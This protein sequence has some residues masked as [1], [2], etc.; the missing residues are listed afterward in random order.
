MTN[1]MPMLNTNGDLLGFRG[2]DKDITEKKR[3]EEALKESKVFLDNMSDIAYRTDNHGNLSWV[4]PSVKRLTGF[5]P[6]EIIGEPF[7]PLFIEDDHASIIDLYKRTL[8]GESLDNTLTFTSGV[9]CHINSMPMRNEAGDI[10]GAFGIGRDI[11]ETQRAEEELRKSRDLL[12]NLACLVPGAIYQYRLYPDGSSAFPWS[13]PGMNDIYEVTPEDAQKDA[14]LV[15][16][17]LHPEDLAFVND[18]IQES[19][20]TLNTLYCEYR[21]SLPRQGLQWRWSQAQPERTDDGGTL[22]HGITSDITDRKEIENRLQQ[23]QKMESI[24]NL[25]GGI[26]HDFNNILFPI[27]GL[28]EMLLEDLPADSIEYENAREILNAG[29]R[30]SDLVKQI[31][32]F[33][34]QTEQKMMPVRVQR[35]L[36]EVLKLSRSTIPS[37][38]EIDQD[39]QSDCG[40]VKANPTQVHQIAMNL[41]T[42]AYHAVEQSGGKIAVRLREIALESGDLHDSLLETGRYALISISDTGHG[43]DPAA[44][45][46]IFEPYFTTKEQGKGTG[47]GLSVVYGIVKEHDGDIKVFSEVGRGTSFSVYLPL[48]EKT[49]ETVSVVNV[50]RCETGIERILLVDDEDAIAKLESQM[51]KRLGYKVT[52]RV[53]SVEAL[54]A[55]EANPEAFDL[56]ITD[57]TMP[58]M[59]GDKLAKK[60]ISIK[61]DIPI[62]I[63]TGFSER[64]TDEK[65]KAIGIKG[66]L[67]KPVVKS[68]MAK[69]VRKVLDESKCFAND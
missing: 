36:Q 21:V 45:D 22:W 33:S 59:T 37:D 65:T 48:E 6:E 40:S 8:M 53:S 31:L 34:R 41:I 15:F 61:P 2:V 4:N 35:I 42:N 16:E 9:V 57:M 11:T 18:R 55:F 5:S 43:I 38:I 54:K 52:A 49:S 44:L 51:L 20:R 26:A 46:R 56:V 29:K 63:C 14:A 58:N 64:L 27:V 50:E 1:G 39:I 30:G 47:L 28:S 3:A 67:M 12:E 23:A 62:V 25:A 32:S 13:S 7:L 69:M 66:F 60:L 19:A 68:E 17:R 24:G 10:I